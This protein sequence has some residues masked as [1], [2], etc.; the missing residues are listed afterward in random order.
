MTSS[1]KTIQRDFFFFQL[2]PRMRKD[3][4]KGAIHVGN[5]SCSSEDLLRVELHKVRI[6]ANLILAV[7]S[8]GRIVSEILF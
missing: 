5:T 3:K 1:E 4:H 7:S 6:V 8:I 2:P